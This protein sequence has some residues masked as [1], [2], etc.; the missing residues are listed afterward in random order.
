MTGRSGFWQYYFGTVLR[1]K[2]SF[3]ALLVDDR[4]LRFGA[5]ALLINAFLYT[6]VYVFLTIG[7]GAPSAFKPWLPIPVDRYYA[8]DRF[9]LAPSMFLCWLVAAGVLRLL[10]RAFG[11]RGSARD[12]L[13]VLGFAI[14]IACLASLLHDL[15]ETFLGALGVISFRE[16]EVALNSPTVWRAVLWVC[17]GASIL[18]FMVLFTKAAAVVQKLRRGPA[19]VAGLLSYIIYQFLF[20][21]FNR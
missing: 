10:G 16:Y 12:T 18:W 8:Y 1:P 19:L 13:S 4:R 9:M 3:E 11:G 20:L 14:S 15:P 21:I 2:R 5:I 17:Y 6:L 7:G